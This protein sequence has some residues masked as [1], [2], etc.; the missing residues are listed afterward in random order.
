MMTRRE[1][2]KKVALAAGALTVAPSLLKGEN[3]V[4]HVSTSPGPFKVPELG[5]PYDALEP[6]IDAET[7]RIHHD[8]HNAAYV[9]NLNKAIA[10]APES[11]QK[12]SV[13]ELLLNLNHAAEISDR[14]PVH[15]DIPEDSRCQRSTMFLKLII[16][17]QPGVFLAG[18]FAILGE[19]GKKC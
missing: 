3:P 6:Y 9:D 15:R 8:K 10:E 18:L 19:A 11:L 13:D 7:M 5:Y 17:Q 2:I 12:E 4:S 16:G 14:A 1:A